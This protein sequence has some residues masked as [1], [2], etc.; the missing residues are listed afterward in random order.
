MILTFATFADVY[1]ERVS[2]KGYGCI[3]ELKHLHHRESR[4]EALLSETDKEASQ[5]VEN[6]GDK[7]VYHFWST[8]LVSLL[9]SF[10]NFRASIVKYRKDLRMP[11]LLAAQSRS[12]YFVITL[13][14]LFFFIFIHASRMVIF[15]IL[16]KWEAGAPPYQVVNTRQNYSFNERVQEVPKLRINSIKRQYFL[17]ENFGKGREIISLDD[18]DAY[19]N[20]RAEVFA[21]ERL[22]NA[23]RGLGDVDKRRAFSFASAR[24][25]DLRAIYNAP[26]RIVGA[27]IVCGIGFP[28]GFV[29]RSM[30]FLLSVS[31]R[32]PITPDNSLALPVSGSLDTAQDQPRRDRKR[33]AGE[34]NLDRWGG[35]R[36][37]G[38]L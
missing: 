30:G 37:L 38:R 1:Q 15:M 9:V 2:I 5:R 3:A 19:L 8:S 12:P 21:D 14:F 20:G 27:C 11:R 10:E 6:I 25:V 36:D 17:G 33:V 29:D 7:S 18:R 26:E 32:A 35:T 34:S 24:C 28:G 4:E 13:S 16:T 22:R 23:I 31:C